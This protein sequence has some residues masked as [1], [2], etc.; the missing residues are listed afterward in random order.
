MRMT[1]NLQLER[2]K[3]MTAQKVRNHWNVVCGH[4]EEGDS[5]NW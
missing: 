4:S 1:K 2:V 5:E 3:N